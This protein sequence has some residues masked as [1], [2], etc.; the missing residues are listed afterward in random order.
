[1]KRLL[2]Y[3]YLRQRLGTLS[4]RAHL[5]ALVV[6]SVLPFLVFAFLVLNLF[7]S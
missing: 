4:L 3:E 7:A 1:M 5:F 2:G 6:V